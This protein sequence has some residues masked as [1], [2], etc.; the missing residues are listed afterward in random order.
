M[1]DDIN[2]HA[3]QNSELS[4]FVAGLHGH[5]HEGSDKGRGEKLTDDGFSNRKRARKR[6]Q[7]RDTATDGSKRTETEIYKSRRELVDVRR[8]GNKVEGAWDEL[9]NQLKGRSPSHPQKEIGAHATLDAAPGYRPTAK[10]YKQHNSDVEE[11][12]GDY[13]KASQLM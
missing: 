5:G 9:L 3:R 4:R 13:E 7:R 1:Q 2:W 8:R 10:H 6:K 12:C 11:E